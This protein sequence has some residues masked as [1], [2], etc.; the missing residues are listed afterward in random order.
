MQGYTN[1]QINFIIIIIIIIIFNELHI[2]P[3]LYNMSHKILM[4]QI[5]HNKKH[6]YEHITLSY[7]IKL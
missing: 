2:L 7:H 4:Y 5:W 6:L 1:K 3:I